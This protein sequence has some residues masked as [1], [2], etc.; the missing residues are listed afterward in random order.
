VEAARNARQLHA[1]SSSDRKIITNADLRAVNPAPVA[2][3]FHLTAPSVNAAEA[4]D[5]SVANP[6]APPTCDNPQA[7]ALG[8]E[9]QATQLQLDQLRRELQYNPPVVSDNDLDPQ[10]FTPGNSGFNVGAPPLL[11]TQP[12]APARVT[13]VELQERIDVLTKTLRV[14]CEP[15]EAARIH[16]AIY[17]AEEQLNLLQRQYALDQDDYYSKPVTEQIGGNPQLDAERQQIDELQSQIDGL[18]AELAAL[19]SL[20]GQN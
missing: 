12:P 6:P 11:D 5:P 13:E 15:A 7:Q 1:A 16:V 17:Q 19:V 18:K 4:A 8:T 2:S 14:A 3:E 20:P 10:Y 9:L